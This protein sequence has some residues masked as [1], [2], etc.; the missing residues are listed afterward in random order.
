[1]SSATPLS[2]LKRA[3]IIAIGAFIAFAPALPHLFNTGHSYLRYWAMFTGVGAGLLKGDFTITHADGSTETATPLDILGLDA[4]PRTEHHY[5]FD[6]LVITETA[7]FEIAADFCATRVPEG[8]RM[9][10]SGEVGGIDGWV[11]YAADDICAPRET[12]VAEE[13]A[14]NV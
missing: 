2:P 6:R 14:S 1:M 9:D 3:G 12:L 10:Y 4:Y 13:E 8:A 5:T 7:I 11:P